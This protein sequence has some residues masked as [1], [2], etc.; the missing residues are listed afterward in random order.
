MAKSTDL[1]CA[2]FNCYS[3]SYS[4]NDHVRVST[5]ISFFCFPREQSERNAWYNLIKRRENKDGFRI[6]KSI[7]VCEK[8]FLPEKNLQTSWSYLEKID[9]WSQTNFTPLEQLYLNWKAS[10]RAFEMIS[11][12][13]SKGSRLQWVAGLI[14]DWLQYLTWWITSRF[15]RKKTKGLTD[16]ASRTVDFNK[17]QEDELKRLKHS[18]QK[19]SENYGK[20]MWSHFT[21]HVISSNEL[22]NHYTGVPSVDVL[23]A[24]FEYLDLGINS[25]NVVLYNYQKT[26]NDS[27][28]AERPRKLNPF[29]S[30]ILTLVRLRRN[31]DLSH[32]GFLHR[33]I[34]GTVSN[35]V[36]TWINYMYLRL[37]SFCIWP[38]RE[39]ISKIMPSSMKE[40]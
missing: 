16:K 4:F 5:K 40:K 11:K 23:N 29:E 10:K 19:S 38:S 20:N 6:S 18:V 33:I 28:A 1:Q 30:Y 7:R 24:F 15:W 31:F 26:K 14:W 22:C 8:H 35:T 37:G 25:E 39:Q 13:E 12:E 34:E 32:H 17:T 27:S 9:P 36:N 2:S 21:D 3:Y